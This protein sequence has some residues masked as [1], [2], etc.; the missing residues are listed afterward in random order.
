[1]SQ[2]PYRRQRPIPFNLETE[3]VGSSHDRASR[4]FTYTLER[5]GKRW[6]VQIPR[7]HFESEPGRPAKTT[8]MRRQHLASCLLDAMG[9]AEQAR[10]AAANET[11]AAPTNVAPSG[12]AGDTS[13]NLARPATW[14]EFNAL[15]AGAWFVNP[16]DGKVQRKHG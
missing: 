7:A 8:E 2:T 14:N 3:I 4:T 5:N 10:P 15:P 9:G 12:K 11:K 1:M 16:A 6:T 13:N